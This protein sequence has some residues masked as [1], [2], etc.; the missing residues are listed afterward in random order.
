M[1]ADPSLPALIERVAA[2]ARLNAR[3]AEAAIA[4]LVSGSASQDQIKALLSGIAARGP[5]AEEITGGARAMRA[6]MV[7]VPG[8]ESAI[9]VCGTGGDGQGTLNVST[10]V[11]L[12]VAACG[13]PV[14][15]HGNRAMSSRSGSADVLEALGVGIDL[16]PIA[17]SSC[18]H[19]AGI[20]FMFA[21][22]HHPAVK[23]VAQVR[24]ELGFRTIF[25][26]L[27]P[28]SNPARVTR[29]LI[30]VYGPEWVKPVAE[31]LRDLGSASAWVV[32]GTD[33]LDELSIAAPTQVASLRD[34]RIAIFTVAPEDA[35]LSRAPVSAIRGGD[36]CDNAEAI[37][38]LLRGAKGPYRDIVV[39]NAAAALV[40][41]GC[42]ADLREGA[43]LASQGIDNR[44]AAAVLAK[45]IQASNA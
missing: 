10:A 21:Q 44:N 27:G 4:A 29:Q 3:E 32:H 19:E 28:I 43:A 13:V 35:G 6:H 25:N 40:V 23:N 11:A 5:T 26:L 7:A 22:R 38:S 33:G 14:A 9:D 37:V 16:D 8:W 17:A 15:K 2:G 31:A 45:L 18:I 41:A 12:V 20:C 24:R 42:A 36:A 34:G 39:L 1:S 30:G